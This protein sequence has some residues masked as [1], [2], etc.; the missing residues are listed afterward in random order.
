M[1]QEF[2][3]IINSFY[4]FI[5]LKYKIVYLVFKLSV[6]NIWSSFVLIARY[7][8]PIFDKSCPIWDK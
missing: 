3:T 2:G 8:F 7:L 4:R 6:V 5:N 1:L